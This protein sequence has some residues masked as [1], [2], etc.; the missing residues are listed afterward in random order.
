MLRVIGQAIR[1][2]SPAWD[3][4]QPISAEIFGLERSKQHARSLAESQVVT[5]HP[6]QVYSIIDRLNDNAAALLA[7]Y[8]ELCAAVAEGKTV[9]P[10]AEWLIDNYHL[11]EEQIRQ[12]R[13]DLPPGFYRQL[14]KLAEGPLAGHP[15]IFGLVW[16]HVAHTDSHF[17]PALLTDFVNEYQQ[18]QPLEIGELWAVAISLRLILIENLRRISQRII[19]ARRGR[20]AADRLA[21][22]VLDLGDKETS[23]VRFCNQYE[24]WAASKSFAVQLIQRLR[25]QEALAAQTLNWLKLKTDALGLSFEA[26]VNDEHH[27]QAAANVTI[28]NIVTSLRFISDVNWEVWFDSV[29]LVDKLLRTHPNYGEMDFPSRTIYRTAIEELSRGSSYGELNVAQRAIDHAAQ[30]EGSGVAAT[31][32]PGYHLIGPGRAKF[33]TDIGFKPPLLRRV[34]MAVRSLGLAGYLASI[35]ALMAAAVF[36]GIFPLLQP[37]VPLVLLIVLALLALLPA[38]EAGM[39]VVNFAVTRLMDAAVI[40]GLALREGVPKEFR[41]LVVVPSLLT[42]RDDIEE[43]IDRLEVHFLSNA[44]G[45]L[46]FA[47]LT[48]WTDAGTEHAPTDSDLLNVALDGIQRLNLRHSTDRFLLLHRSRRWNPQQNKWIGWER[49]RGKLHELN[50]LLRGATDTSF[51]VIGGK[52]PEA[53]RF[54]LTLD[55]DTKLPRDAARRLVGKLAHALNRPRFDPQSGR[56]VEGHGVL[57]PRVTPSLPIGHYGSLFQRIFSPSRGIDPYVFAVSDVYQDLF[58]EG[59]FAGKG[60]YDIDAFEIALAGKIPENTMLSHDLF[61]GIFARAALVTD[62][63]VVEQYPERY[64]VAAA[65]QHRW[66]RGDWQLLPWMVGSRSTAP[67]VSRRGIPALGLWKMIDNLRRSLAPVAML[68]GLFLGWAFLPVELAAAWT[69]F[70]VFVGIIPPLIPALSGAIPRRLPLTAASRVRS[71]LEDFIHA[72]ALA[73]TNLLF[74]AHQAGLMA[75]AIGRTTYRLAVSRK[76]LLEWTTAAQAEASHKPSI[77]GNYRFM[78]VSLAAGAA[79]VGISFYRADT[80]WIVL[81]PFSVL[82]LAAPAVAYWMSLSPK[83]EDKLDSSPVDRKTLRLVARRTWRF[84]ETFVTPADNMLPPDNFQEDP[85]PLVAHRTSPTNIGLYL[86]SVASAYELG[87]LGLSDAVGKIEATFATIK[88]MEK[89]RGHL[90]NWYDTTNLQPLEPKYVSTVDSGN[91]AGHLIAL[92]NC[93]LSWMVQPN[94]V[95]ARLDGIEDILDILGEDLR[96]IPNDRHILRPIRKHFESQVSALRRAIG[97]A[98]ETPE[99]FSVRLIE[100]AVQSAAIHVT[101]TSIAT[102]LDTAGGRQMLSWATALRETVESHF[103]DASSAPEASNALKKRLLSA[104][105]DMRELA[106]GMEFGFL[107]EPQRLLLSIGYRVAE[108]MRDESCYD[109]LASEARLASFF[110]IAKGDLRTR[111]WFRLGRTVTAVKGGAALVSWSGSMFE[112]LMPSLVM[113]APSGGLLDQTTRLVVLRQIAYASSLGIPWGI[114]ESA[115]SARDIEFTY[116]YSNFGVPGLGLKRGLAD[117][118]VI[119]P[120][121][122]GLAAMVDPRSAAKNFERLAREGGRGDYGF[123]EALDFTLSR[124]R[125]GENVAIVRAYFAHH[126]GMTIVSILNAVKNGEMRDKFHAEPMVRAAELLLQERAPRN[127]PIT[128]ASAA[129]SSPGVATL[130]VVTPTA[131]TFN[132]RAP[133]SPATHL[134]SNGQYS[135]MLTAA[136]AGYSTWNGQALTRWREDSVCDDWGFF[137]FLREPKSGKTWSAGHMP[138]AAPADSYLASFT[139]DKAE[140]HRTDGPFTTTLECVVS[141]EDNAEAR[142]LTIANTGLTAR[143]VELT[144]Y[145][146]L[147]LAQASSDTA[148][149]AFSKMFVET[150]FVDE[151]ETLLAT[152]RRRSPRDPEIWLGQFMLVQG[153]TVGALEFE[154]DRSRFVGVGN[155]TRMPAAL[156]NNERLSN[157]V[158]SVLDPV[159]AMRRRMRIPAGRQVRCTLWTVVADSREAVLDLVDR[160]RQVAAYDRALM[161]AWTQAQIQLR[162]LSIG[163]DEAHLYQ[164]LAS[165]LIY[166]NAVLRA[167]TKTLLQDM[168]PQSALWPQGISGDRP[169]LLVRID[170]TEDIEIVRQLLHAFEYW[171][172]KR[173]VVDLVILNDRGSSYAQDLQGTIEALVRK[174]N[175]PR[176]PGMRGETGQV[177]ALRADLLSQETL[178]VL[179]AVARVVLIGRRGDLASQLS[180]MREAADTPSSQPTELALPPARPKP[181]APSTKHLEFFNGF[182]GFSSDGREYVTVPDADRPTPAPW[183]NVIANSSFGFQCAADGGGYTWVGNSRDNQITGW[184]NDPVSNRLSEAIY[185][186][187]K[188]EGLLISPTLAPLKSGEGTHLV[189]HGFGYSVFER[190]AH[191]LRME[192]LQFV[193]LADSVKLSR[194]RL[195]NNSQSTRILTVTYY[196]EWVLGTARAASAPFMTTVIDEQ[197]RAMFA[198]NPWRTQVGEQIAFADMGGRQTSWTGDRRE[199]LGPFGR[200]AAPRAL[201]SSAALSN[202]TGAGLDPCC[203]LQTVVTIEPGG[204]AEVVIMLGA[205]PNVGEAQSL[206]ARYRSSSIDEVL[207]EVNNYW[208]ETLGTVQ[209]KTPD[210]AFD[211][212]LNG[213]LLYQTLACRMWA[214]SGFYQSSGAYGFRDQLQ[215]S[216]ALLI[217][218]PKIAR[219]HIL[220]A[221]ARQFVEGDFQHWWLPATGM[222]VRTRISDDTVWLANCVSQYVK[223]TGDC[224]IL[225]EIVSFIEGQGLA[226]GEHDAFFQPVLSEDSA[227]LYEHCARALDRSLSYGAHGLPLMGTGDW[228]DGMNRVGEDGR[229]ESV[230]LG[231]F[232]LATLQAFTPVAEERGDAKRADAWR[233]RVKGLRAA[234]EKHGW[235]GAWYRRG[236][237]DDG[238]PLGSAQNEECRIDSIAQ[239]WAILSNGARPERAATAMDESYRQLVRQKDSLALLF[240]PPFDKT[241]KDPGYIKA[242]PPGIRENG[243]QYT[244]GA[245]WSVFAHAK[246]GQAERAHEIFSLLNPINHSRTEQ[247]AITYRVE[248]YVIAA[249]VYSVPPHVGRGGWTWYTGS[250]GWMYRAGLEALLGFTR[251]GSLLRIKPCVPQTWTGFE[252]SAQFGSTRYEIKLARLDD[253][254]ADLPPDVR[255][256]S[257]S[258]F[259]ISLKDDGGVRSITLPLIAAGSKQ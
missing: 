165:H 85:K 77:T 63:E 154:T 194:L 43:L 202:R 169:I 87:W 257:P 59:S 167:P 121:A 163:T 173:L 54:V 57:Q 238:T 215:D 233:D 239:S 206:I 229:G 38:S 15:R 23:A 134:L 125:K 18:V 221:A 188:K 181:D 73:G 177:F 83:L 5:D 145:A 102:D 126:Q 247:E 243:G 242:Y 248:P 142:R 55:A 34:R 213:W 193:P 100:F 46:Y 61:E 27:R 37:E 114:S 156:K 53:V 122:T 246:L 174:I 19:A 42:S 14:P 45:E 235:D 36:A 71:S 132:M 115:F 182:G 127:V 148:H 208:S 98:R 99:Y 203:A 105:D 187:D 65:R 197:S 155:S 153:T 110:A 113:R 8:R 31:E 207:G 109:M 191:K 236:F 58:G 201:A 170:Q 135:V 223:V 234:L 117:N 137:M 258:E 9:T 48:D 7:A 136:G 22:Q 141:S 172:T 138:V 41:T 95:D 237:F 11:V 68:L 101:A 84:F 116:Q 209:V 161:L 250:A 245:I 89:Y 66:V 56:I 255:R 4:T 157:T 131:R 184:S 254:A 211:I 198:R 133:G 227:S 47:L 160:H 33:E 140:I 62:I 64:G 86:L 72:L 222:G 29:S 123:Y 253:G 2:K 35:A 91:L 159:F 76:N 164:T 210:R 80:M 189:R 150:E 25:D 103:K 26:V 106:L 240:T 17:D 158:G 143:E 97:K 244:H 220:R 74:L 104:I 94:D 13:A 228:N 218:R 204:S 88:R 176:A 225:D 149:P 259:L 96:A 75:D 217:T 28:R 241:P 175:S 168:G 199:F 69:L 112:Y 12:T 24:E 118:T 256:I 10:A 231:W 32:D 196:N 178:R 185:V 21:D 119:A 232:L 79:A 130:D 179:P 192:L 67:M 120:Y 190:D 49:K 6:P 108:A 205:A 219:E 139:E 230:W 81:L 3:D 44:D 183:I 107:L 146:E 82:W 195:T 90:Y 50:R 60:I 111:H 52:L 147:V 186:Q 124:L 171:K 20:D 224:D 39:A 249:D 144:S 200:L 252:I 78:A 92:S 166:A 212:M 70:M 226:P 40:P 251:E 16:A 162:H 30:M 128:H 51:I 216:M 129:A 214:R 180:R 152:R 93:C 1:N 151:H